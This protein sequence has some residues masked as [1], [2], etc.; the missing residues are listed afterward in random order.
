[1]SST[2][3]G[4]ELSRRALEAQQT[5]LNTTGH[6]ISNANTPGYTRQIA[7][8]QATTPDILNNMGHQMSVGTGATVETIERARNLFVDRQFRWETSKQQYWETR[9][10]SL[11]QIEGLLN[12]PSDSSLSNDMTEFWNSW[13]DLS[14]NPE[15]LGSRSVVLERAAS[16]ADTFQHI[17]QQI[18][19]MQKGLDSEIRVEISQINDYA[20]Q[21]QDLNEQIKRAEVAGDNP[22]DLKD[23]RDAVVDDISKLMN[24]RVVESKDPSFLNRD[25]S[26]FKLYIGNDSTT[27]QLLVDDTNAYQLEEPTLSG[28]DGLPF[29]E[30][31]WEAGHPLGNT[32][33]D[34]GDKLGKL[35][36]NLLMRGLDVNNTAGQSKESAYLVNLRDNYNKL[37]SGITKAVNDI[38]AMGIDVNGDT[39]LSFFV[40]EGWIEGDPP[41]AATD[42]T[43]ANISVNP[44]LTSDPWKVATGE[45]TY[46]DGFIAQAISSLSSGW[47][48]YAKIINPANP[49]SVTP[50]MSASSFGDYYG[51]AIAELGVD[52]QQ[53]NRMKEGQDVLVTNMY[54]QRESLSGVSLDEE[55]TNLVKFQKSYAAAARMV[56]MM[57]DMLNTIVNGMG[58]TR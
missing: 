35:Q 18:T 43:I 19:E 38:H 29:A 17:D 50:P 45:T 4:L 41:F 2:F 46:G 9:D 28:G 55:M 14:K 10:T 52:A 12:E 39:G 3:F 31:K 6:N 8:L 23:K 5:A 15:N 51:S 11:G 54:N 49:A 24:V 36:A 42:I 44:A 13:S 37:A 22:N 1:M 27:G 53:A 16:L 57:D 25:V 40:P 47:E 34:L 58:I 30:V 32:N 26:V 33:V 20:K 7:N 48:G 56:T 21:I